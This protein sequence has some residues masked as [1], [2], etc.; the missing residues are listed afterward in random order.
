MDV[1]SVGPVPTPLLYFATHELQTGTGIMIT[2][3]HNPPE[4]NGLKMMIGGVTPSS[5][6]EFR[7]RCTTCEHNTLSAR[8]AARFQPPDIA[9]AFIAKMLPDLRTRPPTRSWLWDCGNGVAGGIALR[10]IEALGCT[11]TPTVLR[12]RRQLS[13][14]LIRTPAE[15]ENLQVPDRQGQRNSAQ[16]S[17]WPLMAT[18]IGLASFTPTGDIIWLRQI[19]DVFCRG[20]FVA[21]TPARP[22]FLM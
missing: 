11:V 3:S 20:H 7:P 4:Y 14:P 15:P 6:S 16:T 13:Q 12:G 9:P 18:A 10:I 22:S 19:D 5:K 2:G 17:A 1:I 21:A 8:A